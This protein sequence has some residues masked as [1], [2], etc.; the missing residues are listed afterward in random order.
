MGWLVFAGVWTV[1]IV[2]VVIPT[3]KLMARRSDGYPP[4][5][6]G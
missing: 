5:H 2:V 4:H 1:L 6:Q 3:C